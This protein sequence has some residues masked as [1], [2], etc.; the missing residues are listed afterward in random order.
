[1]LALKYLLKNPIK[2]LRHW[3]LFYLSNMMIKNFKQVFALIVFLFSSLFVLAQ[4]PPF[5][6]EIQ[7]FKHKDSISFPA[8]GQ[9]LLVGS[10]SFTKW[11]D[12]QSYF[13]EHP[14]I[15]RGFGGSSLP[16]MIRYVHDVVTAYAPKQIIIYCG[17]NDI[18]ASDTV[19]A[20]LVLE[21]FKTLFGLIRDSLPK[22]PIWFVSIKPSPSRWKMEPVFLEANALIKAFL[23]KQKRTGYIDIHQDMLL[24]DGAVDGSLFVG[25]KLHM[26]PKGYAIW[27]K[28][29]APVLK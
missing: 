22:T 18:A 9:I 21:R 1:M 6:K 19:K 4:N 11:T 25:D 16:D 20:A 29:M 5:Y 26:N 8:K 13:P 17:E 23:K 15:N 27:Q 7:A 28:K 24:A 12:A 2:L 3:A 14:L 10:S